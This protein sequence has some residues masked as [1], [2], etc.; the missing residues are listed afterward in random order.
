MPDT[1]WAF[2][3]FK[4]SVAGADVVRTTRRVRNRWNN[5]D[6]I[7]HDNQGVPR[8]TN[9]GEY[10]GTTEIEVSTQEAAAILRA[11]P[12]GG[13]DINNLVTVSGTWMPKSGQSGKFEAQGFIPEGEITDE[14]N[15]ESMTTVTVHHLVPLKLGD[16]SV[17]EE[18]T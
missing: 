8:G 17:R 11:V 7:V 12:D 15:N 9:P 2:A 5:N 13:G 6:E 18:I 14:P 10:E 3:R 4:L 16:K 1:T